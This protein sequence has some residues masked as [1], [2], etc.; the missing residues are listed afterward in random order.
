MAQASV[1]GFAAGLLVGVLLPWRWTVAL[2]IV[3]SI[4]YSAV[5]IAQTPER[6]PWVAYAFLFLFV[7]A[8]QIIAP[9]WFG[10]ALGIAIRR[11]SKDRL[12]LRLVLT[13]AAAALVA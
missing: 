13:M 9:V 7:V 5:F 12:A 8:P 4:A 1:W 2:A 6:G 10:S 11:W 3:A